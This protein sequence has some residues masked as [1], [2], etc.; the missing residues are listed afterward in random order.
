MSI[1]NI[2]YTMSFILLWILNTNINLASPPE[3]PNYLITEN[4]Y[5]E[6]KTVEATKNRDRAEMNIT[7]NKINTNKLTG[8][9]NSKGKVIISF[10]S[11]EFDK[12]REENYEYQIL[13][14]DDING[15]NTTRKKRSVQTLQNQNLDIDTENKIISIDK[16]D[17]NNFYIGR[18]NSQT[19][20]F[21][22]IWDISVQMEIVPTSFADQIQFYRKPFAEVIEVGNK[23]LLWIGNLL[24]VNRTQGTGL[25]NPEDGIG[26]YNFSLDSSTNNPQNL[27]FIGAAGSPVTAAKFL[28]GNDSL[29]KGRSFAV[30]RERE[31]D[32]G[33][34]FYTTSG[35]NS[36]ASYGLSYPTKK[37]T[38]NNYGWILATK[39]MLDVTNTYD[40]I[41]QYNAYTIVN[42][43]PITLRFRHWNNTATSDRDE[44]Y[45]IIPTN[46]LRIPIKISLKEDVNV[47]GN[48]VEIGRPYSIYETITEEALSVSKVGRLQSIPNT[49]YT[50]IQAITLPTGMAMAKTATELRFT[51]TVSGVK[52]E[53][54]IDKEKE[55]FTLINWDGKAIN[56]EIIIETP[57]TMKKI[58]RIKISERLSEN[59]GEMVIILDKR[60]NIIPQRLPG[61]TGIWVDGTGVLR[62]KINDT[63]S[64]GEF[65]ELMKVEGGYTSKTPNTQ[66]IVQS[67]KGLN[68]KNVAGSYEVWS[69]IDG[70]NSI[71]L[72]S[73]GI[74]SD[75]NSLT[76]LRVELDKNRQTETRENEFT[77]ANE[78]KT[79]SYVGRLK[80]EYIYEE[81]KA[82]ASLNMS[83]VSIAQELK[84]HSG[85]TNGISS[86][87]N[88]KLNFLG[89]SRVFDT[90]GV[91]NGQSIVNELEVTGSKSGVL[92]A[93]NGILTTGK[94]IKV[95]YKN[96]GIE[97]GIK[98]SGELF[99]LKKE[100]K[101]INEIF[102][103]KIY[104]KAAG[105]IFLGQMEVDIFNQGTTFEILP[106]KGKLDFGDFFPGDIK[107]AESL[108][109]FK[110]PTNAK[111][112]IDLSST[113]N[114]NM[115]RQNSGI[116]SQTTIPLKNIQVKDL[117]SNSGNVNSFKILGEAITT[118]DTESGEYKGILDVIITVIP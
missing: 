29:I 48:I 10:P 27:M 12:I 21:E 20:S 16:N 100:N 23:K 69:S 42:Q 117:K 45:T 6:V 11:E 98:S 104:Y 118:K 102:T 113:N 33:S 83:D 68:K 4:P 5:K 105:K 13:N 35:L 112:L 22:K 73:K 108:I 55:I 56:D 106:G 91:K 88:I 2:I 95:E 85:N 8:I 7:V 15:S 67:V 89:N 24:R 115:Y 14:S 70:E 111:I 30:S 80:K 109:E 31:S 47:N 51:K 92:K 107:K 43:L 71:G 57:T 77:L 87:S 60:L 25:G 58:I 93:D 17:T 32:I 49:P 52:Y 82:Q 90:I 36:L 53:F 62:E 96:L 64:L 94:D 72:L 66:M 63:R 99:I 1:K 79:Y 54:Y 103:I 9:K 41:L 50:D 34:D 38:D 65:P 97:I 84:W 19:G 46:G 86:I 75:Y 28:F 44:T 3:A 40:R 76:K 78:G 114:N 37:S 81:I 26:Y 110:N 74:L 18:R 101:P 116:T 39:L 59:I 61:E